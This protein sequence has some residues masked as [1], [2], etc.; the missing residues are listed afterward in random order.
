[1]PNNDLSKEGLRI[2]PCPRISEE[3]LAHLN[4]MFP[5]KC[6]HPEDTVSSIFFYAGARQA[7]RYLIRVYEEQNE[8]VL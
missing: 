1:M 2:P 7:V 5:E 4:A 3:L 6:P 8:N